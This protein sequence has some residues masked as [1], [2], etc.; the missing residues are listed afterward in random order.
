MVNVS[1]IVAVDTSVLTE[2]IGKLSSAKTERVLSG[3]D[4]VLGR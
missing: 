2:R 1:R 4:V 3:I